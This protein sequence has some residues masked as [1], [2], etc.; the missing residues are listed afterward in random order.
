MASHNSDPMHLSEKNDVTVHN[1]Y[2]AGPSSVAS[3]DNGSSHSDEEDSIHRLSDEIE[4]QTTR[5]SRMSEKSNT[6][7]SGD[8]RRTASNTLNNVL[9]RL[10]TRIRD[11]PPPP[12]D[13]GLRAWT[14]VACGFLVIFTTWGYVNAFGAFQNYYTGVL[15]VSASAISWIGSVQIFLSLSLGVLTGRLLDAGFFYPTFIVGATIQVLGVFM[16]SI[17]TKYWQ[18]MLTQGVLTGLGNGIFFTP[19]LAMITTY[20]DK[21]RGIAVGL[22]TTGNSLGGAIYPVIARQMLPQVGFGWTARVLGFINLAC[23]LVALAFLKPRLPPRKSGPLV[24]VTALKDPV[25][26]AFTFAIF[27]AMW[28]NYYTFYYIGS[29]GRETLGLSYSSSTI[30]TIIINAVGIPMRLAVPLIADRIGPVN[31][32]VPILFIWTIVAFSWLAVHDITGYY[33]FACFFGAASGATQS[34]IPTSLASITPKLSMVGARIGMGFGIVS[35]A[36]LTGPPLGGA[37]QTSDGGLFLAPE[38]WAACVMAVACVLVVTARVKKAG[39]ELR[40]RC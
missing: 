27:F 25:F 29:Y 21:R 26:L 17:S 34:L 13:G 23:L 31:V 20:F 28:A 36:S 16:M 33:I 1:A 3:T 18:L 14:Q 19:T 9:S 40:R 35:I 38:I 6:R 11:E 8:L 32:Q 12:P 7:A 37:L 4:R 10:S 5:K 24:D 15:P 22:V 2:G 30:L 39:W